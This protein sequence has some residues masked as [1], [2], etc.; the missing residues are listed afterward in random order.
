[1]KTLQTRA[2]KTVAA[3]NDNDLYSNGSELKV[4]LNHLSFKFGNPIF[5][6]PVHSLSLTTLDVLLS[7]EDSNV[8]VGTAYTRCV[9]SSWY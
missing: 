8:S 2:W 4:L 9:C 7:K 1:M 3:A 5:L 6:I